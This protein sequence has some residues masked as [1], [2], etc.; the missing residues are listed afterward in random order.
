MNIR[1]YFV[2]GVIVLPVVT[3]NAAAVVPLE[4][5]ELA[6]H[7]IAHPDAMESVDGQYCIRYIQGFIDG[8]VATDER[9]MLNVEADA[10]RKETFTERAFRTRHSSD[11][12][13][14]RASRYAGYCLGTPVPL[15]EVVDRVVKDL[16]DQEPSEGEELAGEAVYSSLRKHYPC[17]LPASEE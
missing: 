7:C 12:T 1:M 4:A 15:R 9:V 3:Q 11:A 5:R 2:I 17:K 13:R 8:A 14:L 6:E 10:N 16:L